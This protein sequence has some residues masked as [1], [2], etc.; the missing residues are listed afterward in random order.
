VP[1]THQCNIAPVRA[2]ARIAWTVISLLIVQGIAVGL[3]ALPVAWALG[4]LVVR[5]SASPSARLTILSFV[6]LPAYVLFALILVFV[7]PLGSRLAGWHTLDGEEMKIADFEWPLLDWARYNAGIQLTRSLAGWLFRATPIWSAHLR[8]QGARI[9][10]RVF[11]NTL[12]LSDYNLLEFGDDVVIGG[13][14]HLS[15]HTVEAGIVKTGGVRLGRGVTIG[16]G[17]VI[18]IDVS[19]AP[20]LQIGAMSLVPKHTSLR[21]PTVYA[22]IPARR[23]A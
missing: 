1:T 10:R 9:G 11:I 16:L 18:D 21:V 22:G 17:T 5:T 13:D 23:I 12:H 3:S 2:A 8:C 14:V 4:Q 6:V 20:G 15:G 7:S 19:I